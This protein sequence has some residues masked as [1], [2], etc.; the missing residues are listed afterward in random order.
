MQMIYTITYSFDNTVTS[1]IM[2][3]LFLAEQAPSLA[4]DDGISIFSGVV[5][6]A[7]IHPSTGE[8]DKSLYNLDYN[9]KNNKE[10][11]GSNRLIGLQTLFWCCS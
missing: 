1:S 5:A 7:T 6:P 4:A 2:D 9:I 3:F 8:Y 10:K 11:S